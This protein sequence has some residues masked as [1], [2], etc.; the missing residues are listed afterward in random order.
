MMRPQPSSNT[1]TINTAAGIAQDCD[2]RKIRAPDFTTISRIIKQLKL[3]SLT[4]VP[5]KTA[6]SLPT[7]C[8]Y[9]YRIRDPFINRLI[10]NVDLMANYTI[11][12][13]RIILCR[14]TAFHK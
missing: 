8:A 5:Q 6:I 9:L 10:R 4:K 1:C 2:C 13:H 11:I 7:D 14:K 3:V 12:I